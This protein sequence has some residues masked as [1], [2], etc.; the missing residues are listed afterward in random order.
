MPAK[1]GNM[2]QV[3]VMIKPASGLC[4][5]RCKYCFYADVASL[6]EVKSYGIMTA[7][8]TQ[9]VLQNLF[10]DL[11]DGDTLAVAFQGGE[12]TLAGLG[13]F[14]E[15]A[16]LA[17]QLRPG[18]RVS[19]ALQ[20]NGSQLDEEWCRFLKQHRFLVGLSLD[21]YAEAHNRYRVDENGAG[22]YA[23]V[24]RAKK[25]MGDAGVEYNVLCTLT[26]ELARHPQKI[27]NTLL[28]LKIKYVQFT[29][30]L[31]RLEQ[32]QDEWALTP[33]RFASFYQSIFALWK[34]EVEKGNYISVKLFD[35][36]V[37]LL[38]RREV[39]ACG[40]HGDCQLQY[41]VEANGGVYPCDFY[42]LDRYYGGNLARQPLHE[43]AEQLQNT[44]FLQSRAELP[45]PCAQCRYLALCQGGCK[46]LQWAMYVD[47]NG[48]CGYRQLLDT[49]GQPLCTV[50]SRLLAG[51]R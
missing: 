33:Q 31:G 35:D 42:V 16:R 46:R 49:I 5:Y 15:F 1:G 30:C 9:A 21:G 27:W 2:K 50:G 12:P 7:E 36:I 23:Q 45:A 6:R 32:G 10:C 43:I 3:S 29:P 34:A 28:Q 4:N 41:V 26:N 17:K 44:N 37:N 39:T 19:Y 25:L 24:L 14:T 38:V 11:S 8:T 13:Y 47:D 22:T 48:Y 40:L 18:V 51:N 20:T